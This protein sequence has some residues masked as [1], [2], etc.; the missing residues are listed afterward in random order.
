M[1]FKDYY[2]ILGVEKAASEKDISK[3]YRKMARKYH[4]DLNP[5]DTQ[6]QKKFQEVNEANEVLS[7]PDKR[8]KYDQYGKDWE[9]A[10]QFEKAQSQQRQT[11]RPHP[12]EAFNS[13]YSSEGDFSEFFESLF[14]RSAGAKQGANVKLR[15]QDL[16]ANLSLNLKD[17]FESKQQIFTI[18]NRQIRITIPAGVEDGQTLK[19]PGHGN[20]GV[21]GGPNGDL[22]VKFSITNNTPF[23]R[24]GNNLYSEV[25]L[26]LYTALLGGEITAD[27]F[28][29][30]VK[31]TVK[32]ETQNNTKVRLKNKGFPIFKKDK[33][34]GDLI[35][36][37]KI[38]NPKNLSAKEKELFSELSKL[39]N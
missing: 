39:R 31:L 10:E 29:S 25:E 2:K 22:L 30:K 19:I 34:F 14:G 37:Y 33:E 15:G 8:K 32:P 17:V 7:N 6:A 16:N 3:A 5:K 36:T 9:H 20:P 12:S 23:R 11:R 13:G 27:T 1:Q 26:D 18:N 38:I 35:I 21:N 28:D 4:P 24:E